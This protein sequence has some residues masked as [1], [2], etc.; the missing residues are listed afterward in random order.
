MCVPPFSILLS[1]HFYSLSLLLWSFS[2]LS[3]RGDVWLCFRYLK[4]GLGRTPELFSLVIRLVVS[5]S[6]FSQER[7][8]ASQKNS[9]TPYPRHLQL[10]GRP[11]TRTDSSQPGAW[12]LP[13]LM[14]V[15]L[16]SEGMES[17]VT[18]KA[19][20]RTGLLTSRSV[21]GSS[22]CRKSDS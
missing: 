16:C 1:H 9:P 11:G 8:C 17:L 12:L 3:C 5:P 14:K 15:P 6:N 2:F 18:Q 21:S 7:K 13:T 22:V 10:A 20:P 19:P 4:Q